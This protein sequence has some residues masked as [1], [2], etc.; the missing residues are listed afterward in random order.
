MPSVASLKDFI[1]TSFATREILF[2]S[3]INSRFTA[4][5]DR[6]NNL[7]AI[8]A[9]LEAHRAASGEPNPKMR[10]RLWADTTNSGRVVLK[11]DPD[12][13]GADHEVATRLEA[14]NI[15]FATAGTGTVK[16]GGPINVDTTDVTSS[17]LGALIPYILPANTLSENG[18]VLTLIGFGTHSAG[19]AGGIGAVFGGTTLSSGGQ[20]T[21]TPWIAKAIIVR[22]SATSQKMV[23]FY[24]IKNDNVGST[25]YVDSAAPA[26]TLTGSITAE[27]E[28]TNVSGGPTFIQNVIIVENG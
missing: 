14:R 17:A 10:G 12:G 13:L 15:D 6:I 1:H 7:N 5:R 19:S 21:A 16:L 25:E 3:K 8:M 22:V 23:W 2:P 24:K 28:I 4:V 27:F 20:L 11:L 26:E 18:D 9:E